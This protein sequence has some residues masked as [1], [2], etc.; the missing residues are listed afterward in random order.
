[1]KKSIII[2]I[3]IFNIQSLFSLTPEETVRKAISQINSIPNYTCD[4][5]LDV[6]VEFIKMGK[7]KGKM[8][9]LKPDSVH[10]NIEGF[11]LLPKSDFMSEIRRINSNEFT[12]LEQG[13]EKI[14]NYDAKIIK[15]IPNKM[16]EEMIL[17]QL[18]IDNKN[19]IRKIVMFTKEQGKIEFLI[20]Y[21]TEKYAVAKKITL[22]F[23]IKEMKLPPGMTG[24]LNKFK[25]VEP[26]KGSTSG[27]IVIQYN[28]YKFK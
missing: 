5:E 4:I 21:F 12:I 24:D 9:F 13:T 3:I 6:N 19:Y 22:L 28:N 17:A 1:M 20:D 23:D 2:L 10:Y 27:N 26:S 14:G 8:T 18:W 15:L 16:D 25:K 11:A 7:R